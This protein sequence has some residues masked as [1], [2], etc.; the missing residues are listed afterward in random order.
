MLHINIA[1][2]NYSAEKDGVS[3]IQMKVDHDFWISA[4]S[5]YL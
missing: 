5:I 2:R 1:C 3:Q 4:K